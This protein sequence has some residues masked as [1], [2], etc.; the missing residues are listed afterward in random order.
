MTDTG[1]GLHF[2]ESD[3]TLGCIKIMRRDDLLWL[4]DIL[5]VASGRGER[6]YLLVFE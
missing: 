2:S 6:N 1:Y 3:T 5:T 4:V